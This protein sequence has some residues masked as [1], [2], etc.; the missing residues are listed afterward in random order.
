MGLPVINQS[1]RLDLTAKKVVSI[2]ITYE[3][4]P[5]TYP[6]CPGRQPPPVR[7]KKFQVAYLD[8]TQQRF[9]GTK[10][11]NSRAAGGPISSPV[12]Y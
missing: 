3:C 7:F 8:F 10:I 6:A 11:L 5:S 2:F 4:Q 12:I 9:D 1:F